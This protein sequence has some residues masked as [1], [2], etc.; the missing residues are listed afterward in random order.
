MNLISREPIIVREEASV[1]E[2]VQQVIDARHARSAFV[3][4]EQ[5]KLVGIVTLKDLVEHIFAHRYFRDKKVNG[6]TFEIVHSENAINLAEADPDCVTP[7]DPLE[8]AVQKMIEHGLQELPVVDEVGNVIGDLNLLELLAVWL[9]RSAVHWRSGSGGGV[10]LSHYIEPDLICLHLNAGDK[11][12]ALEEMLALLK[13]SPHVVDVEEIRRVVTDRE[14]LVTT[15]L[16]RGIAIPHGRCSAVRK[17]TIAIGFSPQ[18]IDYA[19][20]D[21]KPVHLI[22]MIVA[23]ECAGFPYAQILG[24]VMQMLRSEDCKQQ[25]LA[26]QRPEQV[27][28]MVEEFDRS[29]ECNPALK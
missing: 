17:G 14:F 27:I 19:S 7:E 3:V 4:D 24:R 15:G 26:C 16:G 6:S 23:P 29:T 5:G 9:E 11:N 13:K 2:T 10:R 21:D 22:I 18:G 1:Y 8:E 28:A 12:A 20:M 25:L